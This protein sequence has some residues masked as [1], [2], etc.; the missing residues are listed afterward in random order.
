MLDYFKGKII[1]YL[2]VTKLVQHV[3]APHRQEPK[4]IHYNEC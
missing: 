4:N 1:K 2:N 3:Y